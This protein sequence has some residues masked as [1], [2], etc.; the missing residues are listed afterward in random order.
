MPTSLITGANGFAGSHMAKYLLDRGQRVIC[1]VRRTSNLNNLKGMD[2]EYRYG[3]IIQR[4]GLSQLLEGVDYIFHFAGKTKV[5]KSN[6]Y[7]QV[8]AYG[9]RNLAEACLD[10]ANKIKMLV[11]VSSLAA[12]GPQQSSAPIDESVSPRPITLYG[13]SKLAGENFIRQICSGKIRWCTIRPAGVYGP[14][15]TDF[16]IYFKMI[17]RGWKVLVS[18]GKRRVSLIH[19]QDLAQIC[20]RAA[21][22]SPDGETYM[23]S[24]GKSYTWEE[25]SDKIARALGKRPTKITIPVWMA[26]FGTFLSEIAGKLKKNPTILN[27]EKLKELKALG[28]VVDVSKAEDELGFFPEYDL[29]GGLRETAKWYRKAGWL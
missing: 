7:M 22:R 26:T 25:I 28:W 14:K 29:L 12:V 27:R 24:D 9:A 4:K 19:A 8:N 21:I 18:D 1:L 6:E 17:N 10:H 23:A 13:R 3:D 11:N 15:D 2:V 20:Y 16:F 5:R